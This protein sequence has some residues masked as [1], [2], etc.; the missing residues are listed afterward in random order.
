MQRTAA[1][2]LLAA[3][4]LA[5]AAP[6]P[7]A[8]ASITTEEAQRLGVKPGQKTRQQEA[9]RGAGTIQTP[10]GAVIVAPQAKPGQKDKDNSPGQPEGGVKQE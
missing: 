6:T 10:D 7:C 8:R 9:P 4:A 2:I 1:W 3:L 5:T